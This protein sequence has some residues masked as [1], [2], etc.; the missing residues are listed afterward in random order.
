MHSEQSFSFDGTPYSK[1]NLYFPFANGW[2]EKINSFLRADWFPAK[3]A[4]H[5]SAFCRLHASFSDML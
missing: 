2:L 3:T 4:V 5:D 1:N